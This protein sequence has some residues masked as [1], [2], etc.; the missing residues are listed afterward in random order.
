M[1]PAAAAAEAAAAAAAAASAAAA[2]AAAVGTQGPGSNGLSQGQSARGTFQVRTVPQLAQTHCQILLAAAARRE[3]H[4]VR[5][6]LFRHPAVQV[7]MMQPP[8]PDTARAQRPQSTDTLLLCRSHACL[9][10]CLEVF[11]SRLTCEILQVRSDAQVREI[12]ARRTHVVQEHFP[13]AMAADDFLARAEAAIA[14]V[15]AFGTTLSSQSMIV[16]TCCLLPSQQM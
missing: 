13:G 1:S 9:E 2:A 4:V 6:A 16:Q 11:C 10:V 15:R 12:L 5:V 8:A 14:Q 7:T 3:R